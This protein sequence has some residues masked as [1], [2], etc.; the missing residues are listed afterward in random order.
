MDAT[1]PAVYL[2][3]PGNCFSK[4]SAVF[5]I[6][7][8]NSSTTWKQNTLYKSNKTKTF[9]YLVTK[10]MQHLVQV[11]KAVI[12]DS[13]FQLAIRSSITLKSKNVTFW[14][15]LIC[16]ISTER[17]NLILNPTKVR[18]ISITFDLLKA[19]YPMTILTQGILKNLCFCIFLIFKILLIAHK[20]M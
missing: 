1:A 12:A 6:S 18:C 8:F 5:G 20:V 16:K 13:I 9:P 19:V 10:A 4:L 15:R 17:K 3:T 11:E 2:P 7:P 14:E